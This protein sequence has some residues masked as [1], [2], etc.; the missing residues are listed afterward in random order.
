MDGRVRDDRDPLCLARDSNEMRGPQT[1]GFGK[2]GAE[3]VYLLKFVKL[4]GVIQVHRPHPH[5]PNSPDV[6]RTFD[7]AGGA[8][9]FDA[10]EAG[11]S[12]DV[13]GA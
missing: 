11:L 9:V 8:G 4:S 10:A 1:R 6:A 2:R 5:R 13:Q 7:K 3:N 12:I